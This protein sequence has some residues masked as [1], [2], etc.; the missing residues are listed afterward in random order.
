MPVSNPQSPPVP[1]APLSGDEAAFIKA[2]VKRFYGDEAVIRSFGPDPSRI[3]IHVETDCPNGMERYDCLGVLFTRID[4]PIGLTVT[5]RG[6]RVF[7]SA[8]LA[9]RQGVIL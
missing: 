6:S 4:R 1:P 5:K 2:T 7:G 8:K 3:D 9:Y